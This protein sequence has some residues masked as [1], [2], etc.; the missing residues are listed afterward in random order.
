MK[1]VVTDSF[2]VLNHITVCL[3]YGS[4]PI[5]ISTAQISVHLLFISL[6]LTVITDMVVLWTSVC[7]FLHMCR[8]TTF[9]MVTSEPN[10][11]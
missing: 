6:S 3:K 4:F 2:V 5:G 1:E 10:G 8:C 9:I 7:R 11:K